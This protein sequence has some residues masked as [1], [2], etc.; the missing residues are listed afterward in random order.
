MVR[1]GFEVELSASRRYWHFG[2]LESRLFCDIKPS[3]QPSPESSDPRGDMFRLRSRVE[4]DVT[5][6]IRAPK[7]SRKNAVSLAEFRTWLTVT[8]DIR[9]FSHP[10]DVLETEVGD[11]ILDPDFHS[12]VYLK[13][14]RLPCSGS[15]LKQYRFAYNFLQ[16]KVNRD[17]QILVDRD[18][19]ANMVRRIWE[20]AIWKHRTAFLPIYVGLLRNSPEALD[21]ESATHFL[22]SS[23]KLLI[24]KHLRGEAGDDKFF[25]NEASSAE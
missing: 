22:Q 7:E 4:R 13:G 21:V 17:R 3:N 18:E 14:M 5:V 23:T 8:L 12:R 15:G 10:S 16:G 1:S 9:G 19:E 20:A 25:Y 6:E 11:L 24:W 2:L